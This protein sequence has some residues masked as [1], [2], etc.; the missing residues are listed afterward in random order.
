MTY[1]IRYRLATSADVSAMT[2]CRLTDPAAGPADS[3]MASYFD[4]Q[5]LPHQA[6]L[7]RVGYVALLRDTVIT[8]IAGH[9][10]TRHGCA[11]EVQY[12][13]VGPGYRRR[14]IATALLRSSADCFSQTGAQKV[15][16]CVDAASPAAEP[17]YE[18]VGASPFRR[19][20]R[21]RRAF[22]GGQTSTL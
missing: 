6:L 3:R 10:T 5:H 21:H 14:G 8:Y 18:S 15:R 2:A 22:E 16:V 20:C 13:F 12:L 4:G 1:D 9:Q 19:F 17:F 7:P 11:R